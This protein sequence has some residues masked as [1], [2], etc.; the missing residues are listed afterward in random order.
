M[1]TSIGHLFIINVL[2]DLHD[3]NGNTIPKMVEYGDY[4]E[5]YLRIARTMPGFPPPCLSHPCVVPG[6]K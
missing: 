2:P 3:T 1:E 5:R 6:V 4:D